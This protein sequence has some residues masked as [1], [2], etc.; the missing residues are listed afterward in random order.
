MEKGGFPEYLRTDK[1]EYL[2]S[3]YQNILYRDIIAR[4]N[5]PSE[6]PIKEAVYYAAS[7]IGKE[8]SFNA[9]KKLAGLSSATTVKEYFEYLENSFL[10]FLIPKYDYSAKKQIYY[11]KKVYFIDPALARIVGFRPTEDYG[12]LLENVVYLSL[13]RTG[14]EIF[15]HR[16]AKECDFLLRDGGRITAAIQVTA[17]YEKTIERETEGLLE[18]MRRYGL[19][20]GLILTHDEK[21]LTEAEGRQITVKPVWEWLLEND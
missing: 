12:R 6:K 2:Q 14:K 8:I 19:K 18:A 15:F 11:N 17:Q 10:L 16:E 9:V 7:N 1:L 4:R 5:L 20:E 3:L 13:K 21:G